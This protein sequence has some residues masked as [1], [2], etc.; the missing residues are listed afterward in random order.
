MPS[1]LEVV[2]AL[3][4]TWRFAWLDR[5]AMRY[6][7]LSHRGVWRSF[8]AGA[9]CYPVDIALV[10]YRL[11]A[12]TLAQSGL[13]HILIVET[14]SYVA[15]WAAYPLIALG[16][17]T[18]LGREEQGFEFIVAY[19]W[20]QVPQAVLSALAVL[21]AKTVLP[22]ELTPDLD[23]LVVAL[24][25]GYEWFIA[26]IAIGAGGWIA[27]AM[28]LIDYVLSSILNLTAVSLY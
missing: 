2:K 26:R 3:Y 16:L 15:G 18:W 9:I 1:L 23:L 27:L 17:C 22:E 28:V 21:V 24:C 10:L 5:G 25:A 8:W 7:D 6:F 14:I 19:N 4:G 13:L 20:A 12:D 11:D